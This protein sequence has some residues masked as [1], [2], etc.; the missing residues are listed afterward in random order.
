MDPSALSLVIVSTFT[1]AAWNLLA[2]RRGSE[3]ET[4]WR[5]QLSIVA[6]GLLPAVAG[7][8][9]LRCLT[10][11]AIA[12]VVGSG[13]CCGFYFVCLARGYSS[14]D[15]TTVYPAARALPVL[16][17]GLADVARNRMPNALGWTGMALVSLGCF[18]VPLRSFADLRLSAYC[19]RGSL[20]IVL[21]ALGTVG[22]S[23]L[24]KLGSEAIAPGPAQ[25]AV[26]GYVFFVVAAAVY[27]L[28]SRLLGLRIWARGSAVGWRRPAAAGLLNFAGYWLIL[29]VYQMVD[30]VS[31][32]VAFRQ[33]SIVLG[34]AAA[35][36]IFREP[37]RRI[38]TAGA[39]VITLGLVVLK[40]W[41][42]APR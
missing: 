34:V 35:F 22:Y 5:M 3:A 28:A 26:Y 23:I 2:R 11:R 33:F 31:Y 20:W 30:R 18:L 10:P 19:N 16:L 13:A 41:G 4:F 12:C 25:A 42:Q 39:L 38:R 29:W 7:L 6:A 36:V 21:T 37:G 14:A 9:I 15:F 8:A 17:V 40:L 32:V 24:D 27:W 1:H